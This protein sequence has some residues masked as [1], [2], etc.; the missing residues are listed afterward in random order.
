MIAFN[1]L[2]WLNEDIPLFEVFEKLRELSRGVNETFTKSHLFLDYDYVIPT[3]L[4]IPLNVS[5]NG[6]AVVSLHV[7]GKADL[8]GIF[9]TGRKVVVHGKVKPR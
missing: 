8:L 5:V 7:E 3:C 2:N 9:W 6:T 4:G 1:E